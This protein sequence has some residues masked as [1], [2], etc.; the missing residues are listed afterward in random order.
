LKVVKP[1][2]GVPEAGNHWFS[3]YHK[4]HLDKLY[5]A[6][7]TYDPCLMY[8]ITTPFGLVGLQTDDILIVADNTFVE[9]EEAELEKAGF[10][11]KKREQLAEG[12]KLQFNGRDIT[13][14]PDKSI[15]IA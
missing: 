3:I 8:S 15:T 6:Q 2:Y 5:M 13:L 14:Q 10:I 11:A 1:L 7:S 9:A 4:H 12:T